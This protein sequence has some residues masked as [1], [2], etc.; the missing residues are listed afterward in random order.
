M[1]FAMQGQMR[2]TYE[3]YHVHLTLRESLL[4]GGSETQS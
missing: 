2:S 3:R 1:E 4:A